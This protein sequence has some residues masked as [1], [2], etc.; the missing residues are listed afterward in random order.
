[1]NAEDK[2]I[3]KLFSVGERL[4]PRLKEEIVSRGPAIEPQLRR[5]IDEDELWRR[6]QEIPIVP[7]VR[8]GRTF[9]KTDTPSKGAQ[10]QVYFATNNL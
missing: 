7:D 3:E 10:R 4:P 9:W 1:M 6:F 5:L 2:L 8:R